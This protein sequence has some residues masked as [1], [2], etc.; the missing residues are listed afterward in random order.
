MRLAL[1]S[2]TVVPLL[3]LFDSRAAIAAVKNAA[4]CRHARTADLWEVVNLAGEWALAWMDLR[5]GW[6]KA[7]VGIGGNE[8]AD[9]LAK[10]GCSGG[11]PV[12]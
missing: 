10:A 2:L 1:E 6:V 4:R 11:G 5:F 12:G 7:H 9:A 8:R 3:V